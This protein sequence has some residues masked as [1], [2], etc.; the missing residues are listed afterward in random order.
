VV[1][2]CSKCQTRFHV[3]DARVPE[4][5]VRVRCSKCKHAFFVRPPHAPAEAGVHAAAEAAASDACIAPEPSFDLE[6]STAPPG[7][8]AADSAFEEEDDWQ[9]AIDPPSA[10]A[11]RRSP[12]TSPAPDP[13][14]NPPRVACTEERHSV[15]EPE[16][17]S[18]ADLDSPESWNLLG[19]AAVGEAEPE[20]AAEAGFEPSE[21]LDI[22]AEVPDEE[23]FAPPPRELRVRSA[24]LG[25]AAQ[26]LGW[27]ALGGLLVA[28]VRGLLV[29]DVRPDVASFSGSVSVAGL[30][31]REIRGRMVDNALVGPIFVVTGTLTNPDSSARAPERAIRVVPL[32]AAAQSLPGATLAGPSLS[33]EA[34]RLGDPARLRVT[35]ERSAGSLARRSLAAG[36]GVAF[37]AVFESLDPA[38]VA[39][40][41]EDATPPALPPRP[42]PPAAE[43]DASDATDAS[44]PS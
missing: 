31:A 38:A 44:S 15:E 3:E 14:P 26:A 36:E 1:I 23:L 32:D 29:A 6:G 2:A 27:I 10:A 42:E 28:L 8:E 37:Q 20:P 40:R 5:G 7:G 22:P 4:A 18:L 12:A 33:R 25:I 17:S 41:L 9:F 19:P 16:T 39:F 21:A 34:V 13:L 24:G 43:A 35:L 30:E 11:E